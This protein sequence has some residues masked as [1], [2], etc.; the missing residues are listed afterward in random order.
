MSHKLENRIVVAPAG[1]GGDYT[2][3]AAASAAVGA[4][5]RFYVAPGTYAE[6]DNVTIAD[7]QS[8]NFDG[9][10]AN[11]DAGFNFQITGNR[12]RAVGK[13]TIGGQGEAVN[14]TLLR[15]IGADNEWDGCDVI[16]NPTV[17]TIP[18]QWY[19]VTVSG[20]GIGGSLKVRLADSVTN[21]KQ[22]TAVSGFLTFIG[23]RTMGK[24]N[25]RVYYCVHSNGAMAVNFGA[26]NM[27]AGAAC[28]GNL[29]HSVSDGITVAGAGT[30]YGFIAAAG[31][32][33]NE[34]VGVSG[35][36]DES[37]IS[38]AGTNNDTDAYVKT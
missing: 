25:I 21:T 27:I 35:P 20:G 23:A 19:P 7:D 33:R 13:L 4:S 6:T 8:W 36:S 24:F 16:I 18:A 37:H 15:Y 22:L 29:I 26:I 30:G 12:S 10:T 2:S 9:V 1:Y 14:N 32:N 38:D 11:F 31:N 3:I 17:P 5:G 28:F 34:I